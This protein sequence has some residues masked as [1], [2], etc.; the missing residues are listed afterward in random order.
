MSFFIDDTFTGSSGRVVN[1]SVSYSGGPGFKFRPGNQLFW[2]KFFL[3]A[4]SGKVP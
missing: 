1:T 2:L 4:N 3:Q